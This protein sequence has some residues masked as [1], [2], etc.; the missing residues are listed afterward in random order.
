MGIG[1]GAGIIT[2]VE[3]PIKLLK[4]PCSISST[5]NGVICL[6]LVKVRVTEL[7][8]AM[9]EV[10]SSS[11]LRTPVPKNMFFLCGSCLFTV[12]RVFSV[13]RL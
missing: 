11:E 2:V 7:L 12:M 1:G 5:A 13:F 9:E 6:L 3:E 8:P 4:K 10:S